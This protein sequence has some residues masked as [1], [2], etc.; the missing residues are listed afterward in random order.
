ML[1]KE[2]DAGVIPPPIA[3]GIVKEIGAY[4]LTFRKLYCYDWVSCLGCSEL[5]F[6]SR[7]STLCRS[8]YPSST[9]RYVCSLAASKAG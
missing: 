2:V 9:L 1:R 3:G 8:A 4:R 5:A 6:N 7:S